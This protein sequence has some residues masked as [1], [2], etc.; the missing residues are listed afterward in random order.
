MLLVILLFVSIGDIAL[1]AASVKELEDPI[2]S[3]YLQMFYQSFGNI[4]GG[5]LLIKFVTP[6]NWYFFETENAICSI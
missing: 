4:M 5:M 3:G 2:L 1:D 6:A